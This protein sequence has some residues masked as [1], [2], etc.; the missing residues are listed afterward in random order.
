ME[1]KIFYRPI[2]HPSTSLKICLFRFLVQS[3]SLRA[4]DLE[5]D[6]TKHLQN[7]F[8]SLKSHGCL[9]LLIHH[10]IFQSFEVNP[11]EPFAIDLKAIHKPWIGALVVVAKTGPL[12]QGGQRVDNSPA[13]SEFSKNRSKSFNS[14][15]CYL[16]S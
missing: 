11:L 16:P 4:N 15:D 5:N 13:P 14:L 7:I 2:F 3:F 9:N 1:F 6:C 8:K 12:E 10:I